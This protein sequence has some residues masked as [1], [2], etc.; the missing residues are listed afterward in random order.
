MWL[1]WV[2]P[3]NNI[4][5]YCVT[6]LVYF[7]QWMDWC[8]ED[9]WKSGVT[10]QSNTKDLKIFKFWLLLPYSIF[11]LYIRRGFANVSVYKMVRGSNQTCFSAYALKVDKNDIVWALHNIWARCNLIYIEDNFR[12]SLFIRTLFWKWL[13]ILNIPISSIKLLC[14]IRLFAIP[15]NAAR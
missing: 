4:H 1:Y 3:P 6:G 8:R 11:Q 12:V 10:L 5:I 9:P 2:V 14:H 7:P 15:W 13:I